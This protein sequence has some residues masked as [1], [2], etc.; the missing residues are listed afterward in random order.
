V[1]Q[2]VLAYVHPEH[3]EGEMC[4]AEELAQWRG[5]KS[6]LDEMWSYVGKTAA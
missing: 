3:V 1:N 5:L 2:A 4:H 6:E